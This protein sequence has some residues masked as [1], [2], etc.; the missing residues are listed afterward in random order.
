MDAIDGVLERARRHIDRYM[1]PEQQRQNLLAFA[2]EDRRAAEAHPPGS[3]RR[4]FL[5]MAAERMEEQAGRPELRAV[6]SAPADPGN[7]ETVWTR[8]PRRSSTVTTSGSPR[9]TT[10]EYLVRRPL[11]S[12]GSQAAAPTN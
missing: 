6:T 3:H 9:S 4:E 7:H 11:R 10:G 8:D 5:L 12:T 2:D 1:T